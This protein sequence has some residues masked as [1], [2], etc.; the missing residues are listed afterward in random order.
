MS[1]TSPSRER[2]GRLPYLPVPVARFAARTLQRSVQRP[3]IPARLQRGWYAGAA[4][5]ARKPRG[6]TATP[7]ELGGVPTTRFEVEGGDSA[8][9]VLYLHGGGYIVGSAR[10]HGCLAAWMAEASGAPVHLP[11]YRLAPEHPYPAALDDTVAAYREL[12]DS[13]PGPDRIAIAG[14]STGAALAVAL[15]LRLREAGEQLPA[16]MV[17]ING[18]LDATYSGASSN[19]SRDVGLRRSWGLAGTDAYRAGQ[20]AGLPEISPLKADLRGLPP[21]HLQVG[22]D[23]LVLSDSETFAERAREAGVKASLERIEGMWHDF[24]LLAG[25]LDEADEALEDV[26]RALRGFWGEAQ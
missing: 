17:L 4:L 16:G 12:A 22:T 24:Q 5:V 7:G 2:A 1:D 15:G 20:D 8:H 9:A 3:S 19:G 25:Q 13:G 26:G 10:T 18:V 23:D 21:V 11:E 6:T 14:D